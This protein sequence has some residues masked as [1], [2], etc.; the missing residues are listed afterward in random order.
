M[1]HEQCRLHSDRIEIVARR[2]IDEDL[3]ANQTKLVDELVKGEML[4]GFT[5][6]WIATEDPVYEWWLVTRCLANE[7]IQVGEMIMD[8]TYGTWWGRKTTGQ[9]VIQDGVFQQIASEMLSRW[10]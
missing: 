2:L 7:L 5:A 9:A 10:G 8:T 4:D 1:N 6:D 3:I